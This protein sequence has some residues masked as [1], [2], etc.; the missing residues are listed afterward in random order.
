MNNLREHVGLWMQLDTNIQQYNSK[1]KDLKTRK[2][3]IEEKIL[4]EI[5][6]KELKNIK[7][8]MSNSNIY[9]NTTYTLP[10]LNNKLLD[11]VL[12]KYL[13]K[14][15]VGKILKDIEQ[16]RERTRKPSINLKRKEIKERKKSTKSKLPIRTK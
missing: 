6:T 16:Q 1:V 4:K 13:S 2:M 15:N 3:N 9:Y 11:D 10:P 8:K 5:E 12:S 14:E 7:F